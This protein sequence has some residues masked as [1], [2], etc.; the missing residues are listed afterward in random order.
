MLER[1]KERAPRLVASGFL[2]LDIVFGLGDPEP[3]FFAG[4]TCGNVAAGLAFLGWDA[5]PVARLRD[6]AA[7]EIVRHDLERWHVR[8]A[9][10]GLGPVAATPIVVERIALSAS[11]VPKHKFLWNCPDCGAYF[12]PYRAV[13]RT[14]VDWIK[15]QL[16]QPQVFFAD[17]VS[18]STI[19]LARHY[20]GTNSVIYFEP[21]AAGDPK[22]FREMLRL[23]TVLKYSVQRARSFSELLRENNAQLEIETAGEDGLRF[24]TRRTTTSWQSLPAHEVTVKDTAGSG[25]WTTV[26]LISA[27]LC[28]GKSSFE[29]ATKQDI[30]LALEYGQAVAALNCQFEGARGAMYDLGRTQFLEAV[31]SIQAR[32]PGGCTEWKISLSQQISTSTVCP[33]CNPK[34]S[35][36]TGSIQKRTNVEVSTRD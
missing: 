26:G 3:K 16:G 32:K 17:R 23:C 28:D 20:H 34:S 22:L 1:K 21:S 8:T 6:D 12:P 35:L 2:A 4:G 14:Q 18:R 30:A 13:L 7:G 27:L 33:S 5:F 36:P 15:E 24:R 19:E 9:H 31:R 11:G 25:D 10:L 29:M